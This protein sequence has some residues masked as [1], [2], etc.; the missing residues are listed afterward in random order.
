MLVMTDLELFSIKF[1]CFLKLAF[2]L[3]YTHTYIYMCECVGVVGV[4]VSWGVGCYV[5]VYY[6]CVW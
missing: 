6:V 2:V 3:N 5:C 4:W 1:L